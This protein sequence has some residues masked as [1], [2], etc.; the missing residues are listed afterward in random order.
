MR[1]H[2]GKCGKV[3]GRAALTHD[4]S[5]CSRPLPVLFCCPQVLCCPPTAHLFWPTSAL[6]SL[7]LSFCSFSQG[8]SGFF[9]SLVFPSGDLVLMEFPQQSPAASAHGDPSH[10]PVSGP[11]PVPESQR[12]SQQVGW[13]M[14]GSRADF[15]IKNNLMTSRNH[16]FSASWLCCPFWPTP[17]DSCSFRG[18]ILLLMGPSTHILYNPKPHRYEWDLSFFFLGPTQMIR[19]LLCIQ[20]HPL[21]LKT[22]C[23]T[24][25]ER[26][27]CS[28]QGIQKGSGD[29]GTYQR[30]YSGQIP[31]FIYKWLI[32]GQEWL[33]G[34]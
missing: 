3:S 26:E 20:A 13:G 17:S 24:P 10:S 5:G 23:V 31:C 25:S 22:K 1:P 12:F 32:S 4:P 8:I 7:L 14:V 28:A 30:L 21:L 29:D 19:V 33:L 15:L 2:W 6:C 18:I 11:F 16:N 34:F 27:G 9:S